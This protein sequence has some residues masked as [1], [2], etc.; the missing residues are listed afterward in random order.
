MAFTER[1]KRLPNELIGVEGVRRF[2]PRINPR[3]NPEDYR[4]VRNAAGFQFA[5]PRSETDGLHMQQRTDLAT[6]DRR[7]TAQQSRIE[8][9]YAQ[10]GRQAR[11]DAQTGSSA[12]AALAQASTAGLSGLPLTGARSVAERDR[13]GQIGRAAAES[14]TAANTMGVSRLN[15]LP[16]VI[17]AQGRTAIEQFAAQAQ[18]DR[19]SLLQRYRE[20]NAAE[21]AQA[22]QLRAEQEAQQ[23]QLALELRGQNLGLIGKQI[24][25]QAS[26][27]R[28]KIG[29]EQ[30]ALDRESR[31]R[32]EA[33]RLE[34]QAALAREN[35]QT[36]RAIALMNAA[37]KRRT[38]ANKARN[39][40]FK[41]GMKI[42]RQLYNGSNPR[43]AS[44]GDV[45]A[46]IADYEGQQIFSNQHSPTEIYQQLIATGFTR[47]QAGRI[48]KGVTGVNPKLSEQG[49]GS[50]LFTTPNL[51]R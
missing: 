46:G 7:N 33:A 40:S 45:S 17:D 18:A 11:T 48:V 30:K 50:S 22:Q 29:A 2:H 35:N 43:Q 9:A 15:R 36:K 24:T 16:T 5:V 47:A 44:K 34:Q 10:L 23:R 31:L 21:A 32:I 37:E 14:A 41:E 6:L 38:A 25:G 49:F 28:A 42:A 13:A 51:F 20:Q 12:L 19:Q 1:D 4:I 8:A 3:L 26:L 39:V 27:Q